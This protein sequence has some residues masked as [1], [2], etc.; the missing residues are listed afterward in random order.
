MLDQRHAKLP[1]NSTS[2]FSGWE[3]H[4]NEWANKLLKIL[5]YCF[6]VLLS[7]AP[8]K[9]DYSGTVWNKLKQEKGR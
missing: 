2:D 3:S 8:K 1:S 4:T 9:M 7:I 6:D 5:D